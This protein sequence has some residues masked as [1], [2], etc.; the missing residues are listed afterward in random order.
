MKNRL[1]AIFDCATNKI[2]DWVSGKELF[3]IGCA[4][5]AVGFLF[6]SPPLA[7]RNYFDAYGD[8]FVLAQ[9]KT[10]RDELYLYIP[11][12]REIYD[13]H[14]PPADLSRDQQD[15]SPL[16]VLPSLVFAAFIFLAGGNI[17]T[18]YLL[19]QFVFSAVIFILLYILGYLLCRS[20]PWALLLATLGTLTPILSGVLSFDFKNDLKILFDF[21][22]KQFIPIV[23]TQIDK[24]RLSR[25]D[26][27]LLMYP[28][29]LS[30]IA[31]FISFFRRPRFIYAVF[32]GIT[33]GILAYVYVTAWIYWMTA[34][35]LVFVLM[36]IFQRHDKILLKN[37]VL[38]WFFYFLTL[39][40]YV[41]NYFRFKSLP[42]SADVAYRLSIFNGR[43]LGIF[44]GN[45][46]DYFVYILMAGAIFF[47]YFRNG[48][49][50]SLE[51]K[52]EGFLFLGLILAAVFVWNIQLL[53]NQSVAI[54]KWRY[55]IGVALYLI[56]FSLTYHWLRYLS[57]KYNSVRAISFFAVVLAL[58][59]FTKYAYN[60]VSILIKPNSETLAYYRFSND[61]VDSWGWINTNLSN[62]PKIFSPSYV[63]SIYLMSYTSARPFLPR[64]HLTLASNHELE[65][66]FLS[67]RKLFHIP[68]ELLRQQ[69][70]G[71]VKLNCNGFDC[72][73]DTGINL[74]KTAFQLYGDG[75]KKTFRQFLTSTGGLA[76][77]PAR[78]IDELIEH[79]NSVPSGVINNVPV[80]YV[81]YGPWE[82]Q[83]GSRV[84]LVANKSLNLVYHSSLVEIYKIKRP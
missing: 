26:S 49:R 61:I 1:R 37:F 60:G 56:L 12:A 63:T 41:V 7:I 24:L 5:V 2:T 42:A 36:I 64:G 53:T 59:V 22:V 44:S 6:I 58:F 19:V 55:P 18:A 15:A 69:L 30:A 23:N 46:L 45:L 78:K 73:P 52:R 4:A 70:E 48:Y 9:L 10:Y 74:N 20:K 62:E 68:S 84:D 81:Y 31:F 34:L 83:L 16:N 33:A 8:K 50:I 14:F 38:L 32:A 65:E 66:R 39:I 11:R 29:Y 47:V 35:G 75:F 72:F 71:K 67:A 43:E 21:T 17:N 76:G 51:Y 27:P 25:V 57:I 80:D 3:L 79:Y 13:G 82:K 28:F 77:M 54:T 40:P